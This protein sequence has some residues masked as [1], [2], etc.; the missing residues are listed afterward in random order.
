MLPSSFEP[1]R[2]G[3][4]TLNHIIVDYIDGWQYLFIMN[5]GYIY[6][7][8]YRPSLLAEKQFDSFIVSS[9]KIAYIMLNH[10]RNKY[11]ML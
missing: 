9:L 11:N 2:L 4:F 1:S 3:G 10:I 6:I 7:Y 8:I 5:T